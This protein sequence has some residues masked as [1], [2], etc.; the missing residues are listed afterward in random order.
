MLEIFET[1][2]KYNFW[3]TSIP[4][5][6]LSRSYYLDKIDSFIGNNLVKVLVGQRRVGKSYLLRQII[7]KLIDN[8]VPPKNILYINKEFTD[9]D[10]ISDYLSLD[11]TINVYKNEIKPTG[12]IYILI[13]EVQSINGWERLVNSY[14]QSYTTEYEIFISGSNSKLLSGELATLLSGRYVE[15]LIFP[16]NYSE[17]IETKQIE[18]S[19]Q[20]YLSYLQSGG[21]PQLFSLPNSESQRQYVSSIKDT[22][23]LRDIVQRYNIKDARLLEDIFVFIVNN[24]SNLVSVN[25]IV[26]YFKSKNR[27]TNYETVSNYLEYII[28]TFI[29]HKVDRYNIKG[30]ETI[31]GTHKYY[32]NDLSFKNFLYSGYGYGI[33]Y[34]LEN[35]IFLQLS[36]SGYKVFTGVVN[37][38]EIDFVAVKEQRRIYIQV[39]YLL[40]E[41]Q[42]IEREFGELEKIKDNYEKFVVSLDDIQLPDRNG[43]KHC[44]A[45]KINEI[46]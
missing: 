6:G 2:K 46:L 24:A 40:A 27:K 41:E 45:W 34:L 28:S 22:I 15:F 33:G 35:L 39:A 43:I 5:N 7:K 32:A 26:N 8:N 18:N 4:P 11:V 38:K 12:K 19:K 31:S 9:F 14:S 20:S 10:F 13:D 17:Y 44:Q 36:I 42:T 30:K 25:S 21:L 16:F 37:G 3:N 29:I 1:L 23:M